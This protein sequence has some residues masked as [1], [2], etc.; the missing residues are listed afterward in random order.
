MAKH[1]IE[2]TDEE[3]TLLVRIDL[4]DSIPRGEDAHARYLANRDPLLALVKSLSERKAIP[5]QRLAYWNDPSYFTGKSKVSH[6]GMFERNGTRGADIYAHPHF[7]PFL[8]YFL[9]GADLPETAIREFEEQIGNLEWFG[10]SDII[11]LTKKTRQIVRSHGL[12]H[13]AVPEE[14]F[15]LAIDNG[16]DHQQAGAV[17]REAMVAKR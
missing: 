3:K 12:T 1:H 15:K 8:R 13:Y 17:R 16:L 7:L 6:K 2:L 10:G 4:R 14:F 5:K 11:D 9:F